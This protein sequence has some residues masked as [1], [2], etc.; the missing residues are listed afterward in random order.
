MKNLLFVAINILAV[1]FGCNF[2]SAPDYKLQGWRETAPRYFAKDYEN[3][4]IN[5]FDGF[6]DESGQKLAK[7]FCIG[8]TFEKPETVLLES[9]ELNS[10]GKTYAATWS[11]NVTLDGTSRY[12]RKEC[13]HLTLDWTFD[14]PQS[15]IYK[16]GAEIVFNL[17]IGGKPETVK[18]QI[19]PAKDYRAE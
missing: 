9:A 16:K 1:V 10:D 7:G 2:G 18:A 3:V 12:A 11:N 13:G 6:Y 5:T 17:Q 4:S 8:T 15:E 19:V 14:R